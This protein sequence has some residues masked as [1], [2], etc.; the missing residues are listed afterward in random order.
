M[1]ECGGVE[2]HGFIPERK[3]KDKRAEEPKIS[4]ASG[5]GAAG[6]RRIQESPPIGAEPTCVTTE[7]GGERGGETGGGDHG[8]DSP[9]E[10]EPTRHDIKVISLRP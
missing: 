5:A 8:N 6:H 4:G 9:L 1:E 2:A 10:A 3:R 7:G